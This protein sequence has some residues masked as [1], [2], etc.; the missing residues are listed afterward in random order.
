MKESQNAHDWAVREFGQ[1]P[2]LEKRLRDRLVTTA[3]Q[4]VMRPTGSLPSRLDIRDLRA[5]YQ[6]VDHPLVDEDIIQ[7]THRERT[8]ERMNR[9]G[10]VL[11]IHDTTQVD[12]TTHRALH[13]E[14]GPIGDGD[15]RGFIQHNSIAIDPATREILG[16]IYQQTFNRVEAP[17]GETRG[18]RYRRVP[19]E[20]S[21]WVEGVRKI[22]IAPPSTRWVHVGDSG[23]DFFDMMEMASR[24]G[25]HFL[26][27][28][29]QNRRVTL[30]GEPESD[31]SGRPT[32]DPTGRLI[33]V[34]RS[35]EP[36]C[37]DS[38]VIPSKGGRPS[39][40]ASL[41]MAAIRLKIE[42]PVGEPK[43]L[44][45]AP[46]PAT[47]ARIWEPDPPEGE[48]ALEWFLGTDLY[49]RRLEDIRQFRDWY[50]SRWG[51][52]EEYHKVQKTGCSEESMRFETA[53][54]MKA[55]LA[56]VSVVAIRIL[57]LRWM[58]DSQPDADA[59]VV[60]SEPEIEIVKKLTGF[61][62]P[63]MSVRQF[64]EAVAKLG[65][66]QGTRNGPPGWQTLWRGYQRLADMVLGFETM[67]PPE[68]R[69]EGLP[70][71]SIWPV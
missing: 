36:Q 49:A 30:P 45:H 13:P 6:F 37:H 15:G 24:I 44:G 21:V 71:S 8:R 42:P 4:L 65:G 20:S 69:N 28:L 66:W 61:E 29:V 52:I 40:V 55:A 50:G 35:L 14:L 70:R 38:I 9:P 7:A 59:E 51:T 22:G 25:Q 26:V 64:V 43:W 5:L 58:R 41:C 67:I 57:S 56:I 1:P 3:A 60:A 47:V 32:P 16:L 17:E 2:R 34:A 48:E 46:I 63:T 33:E 31:L 11:I 12:F 68:P 54:R 62:G 39:R 10:T 27:R 19:R 53:K 18:D 23:A